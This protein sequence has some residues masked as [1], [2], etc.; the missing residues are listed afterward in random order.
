MKTNGEFTTFLENLL[1]HPQEE[2]ELW[3]LTALQ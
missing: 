3:A 2:D 1:W